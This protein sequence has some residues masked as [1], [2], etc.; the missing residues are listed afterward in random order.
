M[1]LLGDF[2]VPSHARAVPVI[3]PDNHAFLWLMDFYI[4]VFFCIVL[5]VSPIVVGHF[6]VIVSFMSV[7]IVFDGM[8]ASF[9]RS[10][11]E[12]FLV[13]RRFFPASA[14]LAMTAP[15]RSVFFSF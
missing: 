1:T 11:K 12:T 6:P 7:T 10:L 4:K 9:L 8:E 15:L 2:A 5:I 14:S 13:E 3:D